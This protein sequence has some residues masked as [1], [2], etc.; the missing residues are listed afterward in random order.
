VPVWVSLPGR[1]RLGQVGTIDV[2]VQTAEI[3]AGTALSNELIARAEQ[4]AAGFAV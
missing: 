1:E 3:V 2:D 4:L